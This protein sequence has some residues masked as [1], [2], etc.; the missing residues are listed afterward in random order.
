MTGRSK[1]PPRRGG[2][3][4]HLAGLAGGPRPESGVLVLARAHQFLKLSQCRANPE[5]IRTTD[6]LAVPIFEEPESATA[7]TE[8]HI[9]VSVAV[10]I[11][12]RGG[13]EP[14]VFDSE[15]PGFDEVG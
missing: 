5:P 15:Q 13:R 10:E 11:T 7:A 6:R 9:V 14:K 2:C 3:N 4:E 1:V 12:E 8:K